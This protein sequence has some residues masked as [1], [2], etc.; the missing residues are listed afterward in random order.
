MY[1]IMW[2]LLTCWQ[3]QVCGVKGEIVMSSEFAVFFFLVF[4]EMAQCVNYKMEGFF[5][6]R[7]IKEGYI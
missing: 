6:N 7:A 5:F 3:Y 1:A 2:L 4:S